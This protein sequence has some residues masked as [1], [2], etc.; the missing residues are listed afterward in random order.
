MAE[1]LNICV[2]NH[3]LWELSFIR[4][5]PRV[6]MNKSKCKFTRTRGK[7]KSP[8]FEA[9]LHHLLATSPWVSGTSLWVS[10]TSIK[11]AEDTDL[12]GLL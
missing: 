6:M 4:E 7:E 9:Q 1:A 11:W 10:G 12:L 8:G 5:K 3:D 2:L